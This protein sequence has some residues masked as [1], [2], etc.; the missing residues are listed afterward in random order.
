MQTDVVD[1]RHF[2]LMNSDGSNNLNLKYYR[3]TQSGYNYLGIGKFYEKLSSC[4]ELKNVLLMFKIYD[5]Y[6]SN[7]S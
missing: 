4:K 2:K 3:F 5:F 6:N 7:S 1:I